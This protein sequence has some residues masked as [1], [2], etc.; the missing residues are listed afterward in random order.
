MK[1]IIMN[2]CQLNQKFEIWWEMLKNFP[3]DPIDNCK[4]LTFEIVDRNNKEMLKVRRKKT[5]FVDEFSTK[6]AVKK[7]YSTLITGY[8]ENGKKAT[9]KDLNNISV[10]RTVYNQYKDHMK[11]TQTGSLSDTLIISM[12]THKVLK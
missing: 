8:L 10:F 2:K 4:G 7:R 9:V 6:E 3:P 1:N 11:N 12:I 5:V